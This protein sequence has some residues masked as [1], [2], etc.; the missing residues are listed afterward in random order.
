MTNDP[1]QSDEVVETVCQPISLNSE[2]IEAS[3]ESDRKL[4]PIA[5][6]TDQPTDNREPVRKPIVIQEKPKTDLK[7]DDRTPK[8]TNNT[9]N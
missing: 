3:V 5:Q 6:P 1:K 8:N 2:G 4:Q 9:P 7:D